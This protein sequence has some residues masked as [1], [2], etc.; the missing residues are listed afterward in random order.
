MSGETGL[1]G[2][3]SPEGSH[4]CHCYHHQPIR[5]QYSDELTN[6][7]PVFITTDPSAPVDHLSPV[8]CPGARTLYYWDVLI[9][10]FNN[11]NICTSF[12]STHSHSCL[13][14][15]ILLWFV[16]KTL[17]F[18]DCF[19]SECLDGILAIYMCYFHEWRPS[20]GI[21][22]L[23]FYSNYIN[24]SVSFPENVSYWRNLPAYVYYT[25][26]FWKSYV[27]VWHPSSFYDLFSQRN[28]SIA[29]YLH[30]NE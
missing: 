23:L 15:F 18:K 27:T 8:P 19:C 24:L 9:F 30:L 20:R 12:L 1:T 26:Q 28:V 6:Q 16:N 21:Y 25:Y 7:R 2:G 13:C 10:D 14:F 3:L 17:S 5:S 22:M 29:C 4:L 11:N